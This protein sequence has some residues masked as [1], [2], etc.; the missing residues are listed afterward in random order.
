MVGEQVEQG[1]VQLVRVQVQQPQPL[2][3]VDVGDAPYEVG[4]GR[5]AI[6]SEGQGILGYEV[7]LDHALADEL[8][9]FPDDVVD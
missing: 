6:A 1:I 8:F 9:D 7:D 4:E 2:Q 3:P 5:V